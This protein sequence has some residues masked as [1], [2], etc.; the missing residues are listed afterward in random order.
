MRTLLWKLH[1]KPTERGA[2]HQGFQLAEGN[3]GAVEEIGRQP[4]LVLITVSDRRAW[5]GGEKEL[6]HER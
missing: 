5:E 2:T 3:G 4:A 1:L 6:S